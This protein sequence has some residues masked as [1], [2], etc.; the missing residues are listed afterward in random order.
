MRK[1][2]YGVGLFSIIFL[3]SF[4]FYLSYRTSLQK[5]SVQAPKTSEVENPMKTAYYLRIKDGRVT[6]YL[7]NGEIYENTEIAEASLPASVQ[8]KISEGYIIHSNQELYSFL[9]NYSS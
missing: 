4:G 9:E 2:S 6:V 1:I 7:E 3:L 8:K 5:D